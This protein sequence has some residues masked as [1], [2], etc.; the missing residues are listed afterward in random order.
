M[1]ESGFGKIWNYEVSA[2]IG[3]EY[4]TKEL[5]EYY[6][7][8][9]NNNVGEKASNSKLTNEI[10]I[11]CRNLYYIE[12]LSMKDIYKEYSNIIGFSAFQSAVLGTTFKNLEIP[13]VSFKFRKIHHKY[14]EAELEFL[15]YSWIQSNLDI[16][17][18]H[19][20]I[21]NDE[22]SIFQ[23]YSYS[24]FKNILLRKI[25]ELGIEYKTNFKGKVKFI[26]AE[27]VVCGGHPLSDEQGSRATIDT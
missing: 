27:K 9:N 5:T 23:N 15:I 4:N 13:S 16:K 19:S 20:I 26:N 7:H 17:A 3:K 22:N 14:T 1:S 2:E 21:V 24:P 25:K 6:K 11:K 18:F 12:A 10:V 8:H